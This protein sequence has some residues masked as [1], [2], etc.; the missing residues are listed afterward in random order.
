MNLL[1]LTCRFSI[2][3]L[4]LA[5]SLAGTEA[6]GQED[7]VEQSELNLEVTS[8]TEMPV[9][10]TSFGAAVCGDAIYTWGGHDG[11]AHEY[12][13]AGQNSVL[14]RLALQG[15]GEWES[16]HDSKTGRQGLAMVSHAGKLYRMGGFEARNQRGEEQ[17]LH[18]VATFEQF[19]PATN[20]WTEL[21]AMPEARSSFDAVVIGDKVYVI[22]GWALAGEGNTQWSDT[23]YAYDLTSVDSEWEK[24]SQPPFQ[25]R[26]LST[27]SQGDRLFVIG[28]MQKQGG[29][30]R[31]VSVYDPETEKW[32]AGPALPGEDG[33][34]GFGNSSFNVGGQICVTTYG[35][36]VYQLST[37][38]SNWKK[39]GSL[40]SGRFFHRLLPVSDDAFALIGGANMESGKTTEV[41][42]IAVNK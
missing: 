11:A 5:A 13:Q 14:R 23:A 19:D 25:R 8:L 33:M 2:V 40:E 22:G 29:P 12:Y 18:S 26:A 9:G 16:V 42:V 28:G 7:H 37:D 10:I 35:G 39:M 41:D 24:L 6:R 38:G 31:S 15:A 20:Q 3:S 17:N 36:H 1:R 27:A 4:V 21:P 32:S 34:E 30:T